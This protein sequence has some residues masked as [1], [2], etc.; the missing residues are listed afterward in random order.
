MI[1]N[2]LG[3]LKAVDIIIINARHYAD[4]YMQFF[5]GKHRITNIRCPHG[6]DE[7]SECTYTQKIYKAQTDLKSYDPNYNMLALV[8]HPK[9]GH[10]IKFINVL[11]I[12]LTK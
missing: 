6:A 9:P 8:C 1:C 7:F 2:T 12:K 11:A 5:F 10:C 3:F 4:G